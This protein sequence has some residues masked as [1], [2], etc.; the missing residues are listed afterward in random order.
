MIILQETAIFRNGII[1]TT[2]KALPNDLID[3]LLANYKKPEDFLKVSLVSYPSTSH[4]TAMVVLVLN[5][6]PSIKHAVR[7]LM[8]RLSPCSS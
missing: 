1:M 6:F 2:Q 7:A 3:S 4:V 8:T 5:S